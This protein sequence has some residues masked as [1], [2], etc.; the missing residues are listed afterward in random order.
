METLTPANLSIQHQP[1]IQQQS[2][3]QQIQLRVLEK[4]RQLA[5]ATLPVAA[6]SLT[7]E[8]YIELQAQLRMQTLTPAKLSIHHQPVIQQQSVEQQGQ[9]N[10]SNQIQ[11]YIDNRIQ[12][13]SFN[14]HTTR[15]NDKNSS[16][17]TFL[18][19]MALNHS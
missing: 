1:V 5:A 16:Y 18:A 3:E 9:L 13:R 19:F 10:N 17:N 11:Q 4:Q 14:Q 7:P 12:E 15:Q 2:V 8:Q 6:Q